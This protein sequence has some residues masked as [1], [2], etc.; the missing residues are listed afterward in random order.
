MDKLDYQQHLPLFFDGL[1]ETEHPYNILPVVPMLIMPIRNAMN[2]K[3]LTVMST[4]LKVLQHMVESVDGMG[5]ALVPHLK[6]ILPAFNLFKNKKRNIGDS[7]PNLLLLL[8]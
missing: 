2:T 1:R 6:Y 4:T 5:L 3:N 8:L 7:D